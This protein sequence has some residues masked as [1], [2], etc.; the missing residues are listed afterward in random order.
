MF[1]VPTNLRV[2][3]DPFVHSLR[4]ASIEQQD[5]ARNFRIGVDHR[6]VLVGLAIANRRMP[7]RFQNVQVFPK[8]LG[9]RRCIRQNEPRDRE[10]QCSQRL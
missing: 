7:G 1:P 4:P 5:I 6:N 8:A 2:C 3:A 9:R 10:R